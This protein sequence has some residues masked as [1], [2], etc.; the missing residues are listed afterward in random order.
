[1]QEGH[2]TYQHMLNILIQLIKKKK[3]YMKIVCEGISL[4]YFLNE[5]QPM[6]Y[7]DH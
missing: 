3:V 5:H 4:Y 2:I 7:I 6:R 1:M